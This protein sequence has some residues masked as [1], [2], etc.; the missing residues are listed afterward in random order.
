[1]SSTSIFSIF[2]VFTMS[3]FQSTELPS[4]LNDFGLIIQQGENEIEINSSQQSIDLSKE[5]FSVFFNIK[6]DD[7]V[8]QNYHS[9]RLV[10]DIDP[11]IF[12]Q[13][14]N[15]KSFDEIPAL[16][17][18][19]SMAGP[20]DGQYECIFFDDQAHHYIFY[21]NEEEKRAELISKEE[22]GTVRLSFEVENYCIQDLEVN[23]ENSNFEKLY[24]VFLIDENLNEKI[25]EGEFVKL[26]VNLQ[27]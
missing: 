12:N 3:I 24:F 20:K 26:I 17:A 21:N 1:M 6:K 7:D 22:N 15:N 11:D 14:E 13:F 25:E 19:T 16:S 8:A 23:I 9:A 4:Q 2:M 27:K 5:K 10:A 18:G